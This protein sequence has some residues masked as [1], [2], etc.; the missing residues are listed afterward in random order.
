MS[1]QITNTQRNRRTA[2]SVVNSVEAEH[3]AWMPVLNLPNHCR[4]GHH[5]H[6]LH[7]PLIVEHDAC[8]IGVESFK[9][10]WAIAGPFA[11]VSIP[12]GRLTPHALNRPACPL[13]FPQPRIGQYGPVAV[14]LDE[15]SETEIDPAQDGLAEVGPAEV[16]LGEVCPAEVGLAEEGPDADGPAEM[17]SPQIGPAEVGPAENSV[18]EVGPA[19]VGPAEEGLP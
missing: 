4:E 17:C 6:R 1:S 2:R 19:E 10:P 9:F 7:T 14:G 8:C 18:A 5:L 3:T 11:P 13:A 12:G 15:I 16:G